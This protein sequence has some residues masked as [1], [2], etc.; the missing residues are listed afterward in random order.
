MFDSRKRRHRGV[1]LFAFCLALGAG[2]C[3][4]DPIVEP[5]PEVETMRLV[6]GSQTIN[7]QPNAACAVT[8]GPIA[9]GSGNTAVSVQWLKAD[10]TPETIVT[11]TDFELAVTPANTAVVTFSRTGAFTGN[12]VGGTNGSTQVNF[13]LFHTGE[14]HL[15]FDCD[16]SLTKS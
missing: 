15:E 4:D 12:L 16:V 3:G 10:G 11:A 5:E 7:V 1:M 13:G 2:D 6:V 8:G 9:I 14:G